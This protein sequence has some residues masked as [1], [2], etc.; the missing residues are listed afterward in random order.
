MRS[1]RVGE[2]QYIFFVNFFL[3]GGGLLEC[4]GHSFAFVAH[5][6]FLRDVW[7]R[8][9]RAALASRRATGTNL[10]THLQL[11]HPSPCLATHLPQLSHQ[12]P[13]YSAVTTVFL[14]EW[15]DR[16]TANAKL[17]QSCV[18]SQHPPTQPIS[19]AY[20]AVLNKVHKRIKKIPP[21]KEYDIKHFFLYFEGQLFWLAR[22][23]ANMLH[24]RTTGKTT[25]V[26]S[27]FSL[28]CSLTSFYLKG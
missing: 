28:L 24:R 17:Q 22:L 8:T 3:G 19:T 10:A 26:C 12:P 7:I 18:L 2:L 13:I 16:L 23:A 14:T 25:G 1:S 9:Q 21:K 11:S 6:E 4:V 20:E 15:L 5:F 27:L